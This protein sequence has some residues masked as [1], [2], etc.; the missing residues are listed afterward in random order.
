MFVGINIKLYKFCDESHFWMDLTNRHGETS[1]NQCWYRCKPNNESYLLN[2]L[3]SSEIILIWPFRV[4]FFT[5]TSWMGDRPKPLR[6]RDC[7]SWDRQ[8]MAWWLY[9]YHNQF[10]H[11]RIGQHQSIYYMYNIIPYGGYIIPYGPG[12]QQ[13]GAIPKSYILAIFVGFSMK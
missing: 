12:F 1:D 8:M 3:K 7:K 5:F 2:H 10:Y 9:P 13:V 4:I 11:F 6:I